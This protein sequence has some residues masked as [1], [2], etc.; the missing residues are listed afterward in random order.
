MTLELR[1]PPTNPRVVAAGLTGD[2]AHRLHE[3]LGDVGL[4]GTDTADE[5]LAEV[6]RGDC[7]LLIINH[8]LSGLPAMDVLSRV[9]ANPDLSDLPVIYLLDRH[10]DSEMGRKLLAQL[11]V[12]QLMLHPVDPEEVAIQAARVLKWPSLPA[13]TGNRLPSPPRPRAE[14]SPPERVEAAPAAVEQTEHPLP[15]P[16]SSEVTETQLTASGEDATLLI[17]DDDEALSQRLAAEAT[18]RGMRTLVAPHPTSAREILRQQHP[19]VV[20]LD[21]AF[22]KTTDDG[23]SLLKE[24]NAR[25]PPVPVLVLTASDTF[26]DRVQVASLGGRGFLQ[27]TLPPSEVLDA[28]GRLLQQLRTNE[29]RVL[30]VDDDPQVLATIRSLLEPEGIRLTTLDDPLRFWDTLEQCTPD[31]LMLDLTMPRLSGIE[32]C[33]VVRNDARWGALPVLFLT[34][35]GDAETVRQVFAAGADDFVSKPIVGPELVTKIVNRLERTLLYR[36]MAEIDPMTGVTNRRKSTHTLRQFLR[37]AERH[38]QPLSLALLDVDHFK[39]I[40]DRFGH[41]T[42]DAVLQQLGQILLRTFRSEDVVARWGGEEFLIGMYG[43]TRI[44]GVQR[45]TDLLEVLRHESLAGPRGERIRLTFSAGVAQFPDD[46][47]DVQAL[48]RAADGALYRAKQAGRDRVLAVGWHPEEPNRDVHSADVVV[49]DDDEV[50]GSLLVHT[51]ETRGYRTQWLK[52]GETAALL[53]GG[54]NPSLRAPVLLLDEDLPDL[55]GLGVLRRIA[56]DGILRHTRV[57]MLGSHARDGGGN[58]AIDLG[59]FDHVAK[60]FSLPVLM[61]RVRRAMEIL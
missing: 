19:D 1:R 43:M 27:K 57:I 59:A 46:G 60:P 29:S 22:P 4:R 55:D 25:V 45:L 36:S 6:S 48:Y 26:L 32:L 61:Q 52:E 21:L 9:R 10:L 47:A 3:R 54:I 2:L 13:G 33:R 12:R 31:L 44:D 16:D 39:Q 18:T 53:L 30:A 58:R 24:L 17:V 49:V 11:G 5:A 14:P 41:G 28:V 51:L 50:L 34:D 38:S 7:S 40:N 42:G 56:R 8:M 37:L 23:L 15:A 20:L 35:G